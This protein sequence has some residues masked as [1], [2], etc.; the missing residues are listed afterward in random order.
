[1]QE[2]ECYPPFPVGSDEIK[3]NANSEVCSGGG[4]SV[5]NKVIPSI[6]NSIINVDDEELEGDGSVIFVIVDSSSI[7]FT[8]SLSTGSFWRMKMF[9]WI[10]YN[11]A[12]LI[13][14]Q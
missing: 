3:V 9:K 11:L 5:Q 8:E 4:L 12:V 2:L 13:L 7:D 10:V 1:M 6:N 14:L